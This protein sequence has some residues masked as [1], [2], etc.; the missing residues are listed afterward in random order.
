ME[1]VKTGFSD[2][3]AAAVASKGEAAIAAGKIME[4]YGNVEYEYAYE[5]DGAIYLWHIEGSRLCAVVFY[6]ELKK[7]P[8]GLFMKQA[9]P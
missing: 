7:S 5:K 2:G 6:L 9:V 3:W 8:E 4:R 1:P